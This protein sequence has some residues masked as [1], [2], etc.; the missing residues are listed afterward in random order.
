MIAAEIKNMGI[1]VIS[2][3]QFRA[4]NEAASSARREKGNEK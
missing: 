2:W 1:E 3:K 4:M